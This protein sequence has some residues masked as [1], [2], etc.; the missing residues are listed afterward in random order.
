MAYVTYDEMMLKNRT[1]KPANPVTD[2]LASAGLDDQQV[3]DLRGLHESSR[4]AVGMA[5]AQLREARTSGDRQRISEAEA[6][7]RQAL[8]YHNHVASQIQPSGLN[9]TPEQRVEKTNSLRQQFATNSGNIKGEYSTAAIDANRAVQDYDP[10]AT[11]K[12]FFSRRPTTDSGASGIESGGERDAINAQIAHIEQANLASKIEADRA[13]A[14]YTP[15]KEF[16]GLTGE[17]NAAFEQRKIDRDR[18]L[19]EEILPAIAAR[20]A[21]IDASKT[22][23]ANEMKSVVDQSD[24]AA[25]LILQQRLAQEQ[26][27]KSTQ[28]DAAVED[29]TGKD[30]TEAAIKAEQLKL[31]NQE[32]KVR[33]ERIGETSKA[34]AA[35]GAAAIENNPQIQTM[36]AKIVNGLKA[37]STS[38]VLSARD[39]AAIG[40]LQDLTDSINEFDAMPEDIRRA[41]AQDL[42]LKLTQEGIRPVGP[43][44]ETSPASQF[45]RTLLQNLPN[46]AYG[47][48][49]LAPD[50]SVQMTDTARKMSGAFQEKLRLLSAKAAR[51]NL[52]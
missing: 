7:H 22:V 2:R 47:V 34:N 28:R 50:S 42:V 45:L 40:T 16:V 4:A 9:Q 26:A 33:T 41:A 3:N 15:G 10:A 20:R 13:K 25:N 32:Q 46:A 39:P 19:R 14:A 12:A 21:G 23:A 8:T 24:T 1:K 35:L 18:R 29:A 43:L 37:V 52:R 49:D 31:R 6:N 11:A 30:R 27:L 44:S 36:L 48:F 17:E 38:D 51:E 5:D